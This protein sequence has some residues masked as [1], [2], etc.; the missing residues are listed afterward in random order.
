MK[1][2]AQASESSLAKASSAESFSE[3]QILEDKG[4]GTW[5][6]TAWISEAQALEARAARAQAWET[7]ACEAQIRASQP[8]Q[9]SLDMGAAPVMK[10]ELLPENVQVPQ[11][12]EN[13]V[14]LTRPLW[15]NK[16]EYI[17][18]QAGYALR[19]GN[20]WRFTFLWLHS[21]GCSFLVIYLFL[22]FLLGIP[23]LFLEMA[24][25]QKLRQGNIG[26]WKVISPWIGGVGYT[27]FMVCFITSLY[28]NVINAW[29]LFYLGQSFQFPLPWEKCPLMKNSSGFDPECAQTTPSLYFWYRMTLMASDRIEDGGPPVFSLS[30]P[31]F[32]S[33][34]VL[35]A[36]MINGLKS[37]GKVIYVLVSASYLIILC[38]LIRSLLL[39]GAVNGLQF[40]AVAEIPSM[41]NVNVW[42]RAGNQVLFS[43]GLGFGAI[44]SVSSHMQPSNN[45][46]SDAFVVAVI[47]LITMLLVTPFIFSVLGFWATVITHHCSEKNTETLLKLVTLGILPPEAQPPPNL[48]GNPTSIF[49]SWFNSLSHSIQR[50]ILSHVPECNL[51]KQFLKIRESTNFVFLAFTEA[52]SF[53]PGSSFWSFIFFLMSLALG[54][55]TMIGIMQGIITPLQDVFSSF[56]K[57]TKSFTVVV[58]MLMF[59]CGLFFTRPSGIYYIVLLNDHWTVLPIIIIIIFENLAVSWP[60]NARSFFADLAIL[61]GHPIYPIIHWL[62]SYLSPI[63]LLI[64][65]V[66][67][68]FQ[69]SLKTKTYV[70]WDSS[71]VCI[72]VGLYY[73]V[74]VAWNLFY[75][76]QSFQ[77]PLPWSLCPLMKNSSGFDPECAWTTPTT[78]FW[79]RKVLK[80]TDEIEIGGIPVMHLSVCLFVTWLIICI[81]MMK[82]PK[83]T[84][85]MLY[86]SVLLPYI[87]L[88]CLLIRSLML[89][90]ANF[91]LKSLLA[92]KVP[93]LYSV[94]VWRRTGNQLFLSL[95]AG[96][97]SFTA[98]SSHIPRSNNC[99]M[100]AFAVSFL[101]LVASMTTTVFVFAVMGHLAIKNNE[102]C[103][104]MNAKTVMDLVAANLLPHEAQPPD[105][106]HHDPSSIYSKWLNN[107]PGQVKERI[108]PHLTNCDLSEQLSEVMVGPGVAI[109]AISNIISV[110]SG[111]TFWAIITF[112]LLVTLG[113]STVIGITRGIITPLQNTFSSLREHSGLLTVGVCV[114]MF[115]SSLLFVRPLGSY[116][117]NLLDDYWTS[118]PLFFVVILETV[119]MAWIYGAR[120]FLADLSIMLGRPIS[121]VYRWLWCF[122]SPFVLLVLFLSA[123]IH[124]FV[125]KIT[126]LAWDSKSSDEVTRTYPSWAKVLLIALIILTILP[127]PAYFFYTFTEVTSASMTHRRATVILKPE[128]KEGLPKAHLWLQVKQ[129]LK[130]VNKMDK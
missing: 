126:Y 65:F 115:L 80:A 18:T 89:K 5:S 119:A 41:Y 13:E 97:G 35:G 116:Y 75:L 102:K 28:L 108:L 110:F 112:V 81:S 78:Y 12:E 49:T 31:L 127:V 93:A 117:V 59:L 19:P 120:R 104:L 45:C 7:Q 70:A 40:L 62:W 94:E 27:S 56:K 54:L 66:I 46:L 37:I 16:T 73:S 82:G 109:V 64:L 90:G 32:M 63:M 124:L 69:L 57:Y 4:P 53:I 15:S 14:L 60:S 84:G 48:Q 61:W 107:L 50:K 8:K 51:E 22:L 98:V 79:Y 25:G 122:L 39:E 1:L 47:N 123:L 74:L 125:K 10:Q 3:S 96:F 88:F 6:M 130:K 83:S 91:G 17:L 23:L 100:D 38:F 113:L 118:L 72:I 34:C 29:T 33:L 71:S 44:V 2:E 11:K 20:L 101:N 58:F 106:L 42:C 95:G 92:A 111:S 30:L 105:S 36:F 68:L 121:P 26:V 21:G 55:S 9:S 86:V 52:M 77:S 24:A 87:I 129:S 67:S 85:K 99:V 76:V 103:Y 43:L 128:A 114:P